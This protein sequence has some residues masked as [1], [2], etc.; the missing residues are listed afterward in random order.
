MVSWVGAKGAYGRDERASDASRAQG[1]AGE[2]QRT[3]V[4]HICISAARRP[5]GRSYRPPLRDPGPVGS[6]SLL[7]GRALGATQAGEARG[8]SM[9]V[10]IVTETFLPKM[11]GIVRMLTEFLDHLRRQGHEALVL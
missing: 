11:D 3:T 1:T 5:D 7:F 10:A 9:R 6:G 8:V 4:A 2:V